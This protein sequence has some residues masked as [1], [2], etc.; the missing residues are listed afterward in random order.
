[1]IHQAF[2]FSDIYDIAWPILVI[3]VSSNSYRA[4]AT[5]KARISLVTS[6]LFTL[7]QATSQ[8]LVDSTVG[9]FICSTT[10]RQFLAVIPPRRHTVA[11]LP[12][13]Q[14]TLRPCH[15][16]TDFFESLL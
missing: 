13:R 3:S 11:Q 2:D 8:L 12:E 4:A 7:T 15:H 1:M 14:R 16:V 6:P 10:K 5:A 9:H